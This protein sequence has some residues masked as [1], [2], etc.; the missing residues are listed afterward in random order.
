MKTVGDLVRA[1]RDLL[2]IG[3]L[4]LLGAAADGVWPLR[5][6]ANRS[7]ALALPGEGVP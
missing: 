5:M 1:R 7:A 4:G 2:K 6:A 3:G